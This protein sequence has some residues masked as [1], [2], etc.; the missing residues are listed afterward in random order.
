VLIEGGGDWLGLE[1]AN[2][3][4]ADSFEGFCT[5]TPSGV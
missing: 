2:E 5:V 1:G 4:V 3:F